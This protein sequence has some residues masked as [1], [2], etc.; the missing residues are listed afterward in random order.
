[1]I[2]LAHNTWAIKDFYSNT[3]HVF[4]TKQTSVIISDSVLDF[5]IENTLMGGV[6][7]F[8]DHSFYD[9]R[10]WFIYTASTQSYILYN[11]L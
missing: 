4:K 3:N 1:M 5:Y 2:I 8:Y 9:P 11:I 6:Q 10:Q 7:I